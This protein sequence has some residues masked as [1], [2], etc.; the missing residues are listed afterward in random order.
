MTCHLIFIISKQILIFQ[1][2]DPFR[3][4]ISILYFQSADAEKFAKSIKD[5]KDQHG[6]DGIDLDVESSG[7][8][9]DIQIH[10][11]KSLREECGSDF[12]I[13]YTVPAL[14]ES[15]DPWMKR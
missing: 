6:L 8:S 9:A 11:I 1:F 4:S 12:Q 15:V 3:Q 5:L 13:T 10:L 14:V 2:S 7:S